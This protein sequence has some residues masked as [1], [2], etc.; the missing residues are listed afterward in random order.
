M[1]E[2]EYKII[3][4]RFG[5]IDG[6]KRTLE[7]VGT[8][9]H[10]SRKRIHQIEK[11]ALKK[12]KEEKQCEQL[13]PFSN[14]SEE[15]KN[16]ETFMKKYTGIVPQKIIKEIQN[17]QKD[18]NSLEAMEKDLLIYLMNCYKQEKNPIILKK[19][20][21]VL[22]EKFLRRNPESSEKQINLAIDNL[23]ISF[24]EEGTLETILGK[25]ILKKI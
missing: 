10:V 8:M 1:T 12:I 9:F 23:F 15:A 19:I 25:Y 18:E 16:R 2:R 22:K 11:K 3:L 17:K 20:K 21:F 4:L 7:E 13:N 5:L 6:R 24:E 14:K